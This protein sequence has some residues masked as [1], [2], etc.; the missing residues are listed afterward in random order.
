MTVKAISE[1]K[2]TTTEEI[3]V[4]ST[5]IVNFFNPC[6]DTDFVT[7]ENAPFDTL[8]YTIDGEAETFT[9][10]EFTVV[11]TPLIGHTLCGD[12]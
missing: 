6:I 12:L 3:E 2:Y 7:I 10:Q 5:F 4:S 11:T 8:Y 1:S 9:H